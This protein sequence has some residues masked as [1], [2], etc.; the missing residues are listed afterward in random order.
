MSR[1]G[2][3]MLHKT[4]AEKILE[5]FWKGHEHSICEMSKLT[6]QHTS[7]SRPIWVDDYG[8]DRRVP[9]SPYRIRVQARKGEP[10]NTR[11][12]AVCV[13][14]DRDEP[15][16]DPRNKAKHDITGR[17]FKEIKNFIKKHIDLLKIFYTHKDEYDIGW[18]LKKLEKRKIAKFKKPNNLC[19]LIVNGKKHAYLNDQSKASAKQYWNQK[20]VKVIDP[21]K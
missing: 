10:F 14:F 12:N 11:T 15:Y 7:L 19:Y 17:E 9:H 4:V 6:P 21:D 5:R 18:L 20:G 13:Y 8:E 1:K 16:I 3:F 2:D